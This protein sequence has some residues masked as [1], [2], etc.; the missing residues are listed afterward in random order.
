MRLLRTK[1]WAWS[2]IVLLKWC[3]L[4]FG[5]ILG[6]YCAESVKRHVGGLVLIAVALAI[7]P[8]VAYFGNDRATP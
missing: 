5:T 6:A 3:C 7:R 2:D 1:V 8:T 4:I